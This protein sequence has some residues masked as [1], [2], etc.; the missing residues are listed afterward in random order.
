MTV[1]A[2]THKGKFFIFKDGWEYNAMLAVLAVLVATIGPGAWSLDHALDLDDDLSGTTGL[3]ALA[4]SG[5]WRP[6]C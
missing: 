2:W 4:Q 6:S 1:A 3:L 5:S